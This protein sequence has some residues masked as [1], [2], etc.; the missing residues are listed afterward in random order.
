ML[1]RPNDPADAPQADGEIAPRPVKFRGAG[2]APRAGRYSGWIALA[3]VIGL[4]Q[5]AGSTGWVNP[6]FLPAPSAIA[7]AIY[8]LAVSGALW[9][10]VSYSFMRICT[11][12]DLG[13]IDGAVVAFAIGTVLLARR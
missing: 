4:W 11:R 6:L 1:E 5:L 8:Q 12:W 2:F 13:H 3:L 9:Q 10:P 7:V